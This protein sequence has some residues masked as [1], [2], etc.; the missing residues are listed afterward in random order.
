VVFG[1]VLFN[2]ADFLL[3]SCFCTIDALLDIFFAIGFATLVILHGAFG[4][5]IAGF[6]AGD[7]S[8]SWALE[9]ARVFATM[10]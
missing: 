2:A 1:F 3:L 5:T 8:L 4:A 9:R 10:I 7:T 6:C